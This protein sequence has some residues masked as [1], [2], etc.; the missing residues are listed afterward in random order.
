MV[1]GRQVRI[2]G[3][4]SPETRLENREKGKCKRVGM[5]TVDGKGKKKVGDIKGW[6]VDG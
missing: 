6:M 4:R 2:R 5:W 1:G 3:Y